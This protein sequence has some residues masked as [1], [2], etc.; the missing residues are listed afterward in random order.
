M[1]VAPTKTSNRGRRKRKSKETD[2]KDTE[3]EGTS[4]KKSKQTKKRRL[5]QYCD[6]V[7]HMYTSV[8]RTDSNSLPEEA[9]LDTGALELSQDTLLCMHACLLEVILQG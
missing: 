3:E 9:S 1:D 4:S 7:Q 5:L 8:C 2:D 6:C